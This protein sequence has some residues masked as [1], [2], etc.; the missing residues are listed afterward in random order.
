[1]GNKND[2]NENNN[3]TSSD[4]N[5]NSNNNSKSEPTRT[6]KLL[7][8]RPNQCTINEYFPSVGIS[9]HVDTHSAFENELLSLSCGSDIVM[10][11]RQPFAPNNLHK[12]IYLP[13][14]SL[15]ILKD[16][17]RYLWEHGIASRKW[18]KIN[19]TLQRRDRRI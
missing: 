7:Q 15:L 17:A 13:R 3:D 2:N 19:G 5:S 1:M 4:N 18:D 16:E 14:R 6:R 11:L 9:S 12:L 10:E 8:T